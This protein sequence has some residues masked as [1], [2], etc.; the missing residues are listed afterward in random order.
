MCGVEKPQHNVA[1]HGCAIY[2][3]GEKLSPVHTWITNDLKEPTR[4]DVNASNNIIIQRL[5]RNCMDL[6]YACNRNMRVMGTN[7]GGTENPQAA[8]APKQEATNF[9]SNSFLLLVAMHLF[10]LAMHLLLL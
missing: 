1:S 5:Y 2:D 3:P 7:V 10:L 6:Q 9:N 4:S 8:Q